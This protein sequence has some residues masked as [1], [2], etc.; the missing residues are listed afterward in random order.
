ML[1]E[2]KGSWRSDSQMLI[3]LESKA[4]GKPE[5]LLAKWRYKVLQSVTKCYKVLQSVGRTCTLHSLRYCSMWQGKSVSI[6][7][8]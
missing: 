8:S 3:L 1:I 4:M 5:C 6:C 2:Q 7:H